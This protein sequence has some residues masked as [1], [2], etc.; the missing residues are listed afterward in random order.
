MERGFFSCLFCG[1]W[2]WSKGSMTFL[3]T[4]HQWVSS[5]EDVTLQILLHTP[6]SP[7]R[8]MKALSLNAYFPLGCTKKYSV[9]KYLNF[10]TLSFASCW[11]DLLEIRNQILVHGPVVSKNHFCGIAWFSQEVYRIHIFIFPD[12]IFLFPVKEGNRIRKVFKHWVMMLTTWSPRIWLFS[13]MCWPPSKRK[14]WHVGRMW[15][16]EASAHKKEWRSHSPLA[17]KRKHSISQLL[18]MVSGS[19]KC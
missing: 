1:L 14:P 9:S 18:R 8:V 17:P 13:S 11:E 15:K 4:Q 3:I 7:P 16:S 6:L 5:Q 12:L 10:S 2:C 19:N